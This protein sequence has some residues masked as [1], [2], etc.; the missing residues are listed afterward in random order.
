MF[1]RIIR[2]YPV[3][4]FFLL[5][6]ALTWGVTFLAAALAGKPF[7]VGKLAASSVIIL[8]NLGPP[9]AAVLVAGVASGADGIR[10]LRF[11]LLRWHVGARWWL[12]VVCGWPAIV[13][14]ALGIYY[15]AGGIVELRPPESP[16]RYQSLLTAILCLP[17]LALFEGVGW[18]GCALPELQRRFTPLTA[19]IIVGVFWACWHLPAF[20]IPGTAQQNTPF[21]G[22]LV[23]TVV[24]SIPFTWLYNNSQSLPVMATFHVTLDYSFFLLPSARQVRVVAVWFGLTLVLSFVLIF[25]ARLTKRCIAPS[26]VRC[27]QP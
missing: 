19:N 9:L 23:G 18:R 2:R 6:C 27:Q 24:I 26:D 20:F 5:A 12:V 7:P 10:R 11:R 22:F 3:V 8:T 16:N 17:I 14:L 4:T 25:A 13:L 1:H 21:L 15:L